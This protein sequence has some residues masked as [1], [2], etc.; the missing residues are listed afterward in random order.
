MGMWTTMLPGPRGGELWGHPP[1]TESSSSTRVIEGNTR[2]D[3]MTCNSS[4][5]IT[6]CLQTAPEPVT[7]LLPLGRIVE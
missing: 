7:S 1:S 6:T 4:K 3:F 5:D 2:I